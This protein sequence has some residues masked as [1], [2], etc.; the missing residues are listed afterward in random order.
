[1]IRNLWD[2]DLA[3]IELAAGNSTAAPRE[4]LLKL[5]SLGHVKLDGG[6]ASLTSKGR[7]RAIALLPAENDLRMSANAKLQHRQPIRTVG[8]SSMHIG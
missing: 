3:L 6:K 2:G 5:A 1:M 7:K 4:V 8:S